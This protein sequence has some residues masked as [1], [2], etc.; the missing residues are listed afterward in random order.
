MKVRL[1]V[2]TLA[3]ASMVLPAEAKPKL[4]YVSST[5]QG[6]HLTIAG[7]YYV[8]PDIHGEIAVGSDYRARVEGKHIVL[9]AGTKRYVYAISETGKIDPQPATVPTPDNSPLLFQNR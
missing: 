5:E 3:V 6:T 9:T 4:A 7:A 2:A 8:S 1:I